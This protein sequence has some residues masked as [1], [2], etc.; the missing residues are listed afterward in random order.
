MTVDKF[1]EDLIVASMVPVMTVM[2][3]MAA[4][5]TAVMAAV[6]ISGDNIMNKVTNRIHKVT[7]LMNIITVVWIY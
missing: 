2:P 7:S 4:V 1:C 5:M 6:M 3:V